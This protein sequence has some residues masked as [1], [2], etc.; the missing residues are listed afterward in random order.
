MRTRDELPPSLADRVEAAA[1]RAHAALRVERHWRLYALA[2]WAFERG[3][4]LDDLEVRR[5]TLEDVY[6]RLTASEQ[7]RS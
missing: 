5:P 1:R 2:R 4:E 6:L 7:P 3:L